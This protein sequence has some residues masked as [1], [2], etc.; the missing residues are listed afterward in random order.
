MRSAGFGK[1]LQR[2]QTQRHVPKS[3]GSSAHGQGMIATGAPTIGVEEESD[4]ARMKSVLEMDSLADYL[5]Q[6]D[7][8]N[9]TFASERERFLHPEDAARE[10]VPTGMLHDV[11]GATT[12]PGDF[13]FRELGVPRRPAWTPG[14][15][16]PEELAAREDA[17]F[18]AWRRGVALREEEIASLSRA[19]Q[20]GGGLAPSV[21][22][23]EKN[24]HVWRQLW[25]VLE[26][27]AVVL[28]I[29]DARNPL[30]YLSE[31]LLRY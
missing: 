23:Y 18:L 4:A 25:R 27:S 24:L 31:D 10:Y 21:T 19:G 8:A 28:N 12:T 3:N 15:T 22:P 2:S 20:G 29:V 13:S 17:A 7:L 6:A 26:R 1:T 9:R 11:P 5:A 14:V 16:T 30:F